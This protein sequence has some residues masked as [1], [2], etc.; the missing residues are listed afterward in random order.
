M[1]KTMIAYCGVDCSVCPDLT[2]N[3]CPGCRQ[4]EW[5]AGDICFPAECCRKKGIAACG[6]CASFPCGEMAG[7]YHESASHAEAYLRMLSLGKV[8]A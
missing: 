7:F 2:G 5:T 8:K 3:K 4:T 1:D 6:E